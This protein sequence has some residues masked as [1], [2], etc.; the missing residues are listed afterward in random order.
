MEEIIKPLM[1][2]KLQVLLNLLVLVQKCCLCYISS[3]ISRALFPPT[4]IF[5]Q[6]PEKR[7]SSMTH[8]W[9]RLLTFWKIFSLSASYL[10]VCRKHIRN[11][12]LEWIQ[13]G[14]FWLNF[15]SFWE[16]FLSQISFCKVRYKDTRWGAGEGGGKLLN[17][18]INIYNGGTCIYVEN[19]KC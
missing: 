17:Y 14:D 7:Y 10:T 13:I 1:I 15:S 3:S 6:R 12:I 11:Q 19:T 18:L 4:I 5:L 9:C 2:A 8:N 16:I